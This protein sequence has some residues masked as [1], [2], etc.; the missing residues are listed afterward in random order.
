VGPRRWRLPPHLACREEDREK[1]K[2]EKEEKKKKII[3]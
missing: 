2:N 1:E 3:K